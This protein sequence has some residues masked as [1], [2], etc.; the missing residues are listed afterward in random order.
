MLHPCRESRTIEEHLTEEP[1]VFPKPLPE[2]WAPVMGA[3]R[4]G[5]IGPPLKIGEECLT[6][7]ASIPNN[8]ETFNWGEC[9]MSSNISSEPGDYSQ[10]PTD[11]ISPS[12]PRMVPGIQTSPQNII[13]EKETSSPTL[14][15]FN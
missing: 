5:R 1:N 10:V 7:A 11:T 12:I 13:A 14:T 15:L 4:K 2:L 3:A 6:L 9:Q 8:S